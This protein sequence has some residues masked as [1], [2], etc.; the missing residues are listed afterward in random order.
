MLGQSVIGQPVETTVQRGHTRAINSLA[1]SPDGKLLVSA[2]DDHTLKLWEVET[3][4]ELRTFNGHKNDVNKVLF[5]PN[6]EWVISGSSDHDIKVWEV[7]TGKLL[8]TYTIPE[9]TIISLAIDPTGTFLAAGSYGDSV[10]VYNTKADSIIYGLKGDRSLP[11]YVDIDAQGKYLLVG[12]DNRKATLHDLKTGK[13]IYEYKEEGGYCGGCPTQVGFV[14]DEVITSSHYKGSG[15]RMRNLSGKTTK[16]FSDQIEE[17]TLSISLSPNNERMVT[18]DEDSVVVWD[19]KTGKH[20]FAL[21][22]KDTDEKPLYGLNRLG[23]RKEHYTDQFEDAAFSPDG[24][25]IATADNTNFIILWDAKTGQ[26]ISTFYGYLTQP[27]KDE[28]DF[29]PNS[30]WEWY[31]HELISIKNKIVLAPDGTHAFRSDRGK[32]VKR[33]DLLTGKVD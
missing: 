19:V 16:L 30:Y 7:T 22:P 10:Y 12:H 15:L 9:Y 31:S 18:V 1:F 4:R 5:H 17:N 21:N 11:N 25:W 20:L 13:L 33:W 3:G 29:D 14:G 26:R 2:S 8:K 6:G 27:G 28:L 23:E 24:N 32:T